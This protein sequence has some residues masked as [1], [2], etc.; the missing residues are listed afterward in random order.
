LISLIADGVKLTGAA[1]VVSMLQRYK[2]E[3][4]SFVNIMPTFAHK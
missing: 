3:S 1:N 2:N 4:F